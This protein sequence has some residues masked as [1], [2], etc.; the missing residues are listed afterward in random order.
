MPGGLDIS[1]ADS[2]YLNRIRECLPHLPVEAVRANHDGLVNDVL[3][4]NERLVFRFPKN[5]TW[6]RDL[7]ANEI[8]VIQLARNYLDVQIP[9]IEYQAADLMAYRFIGGSALQR[10]DILVLDE[11][12]QDVIAHQLATYLKQLHGIPMD[13]VERHQIAQSDTNRG[14]RVWVRLFDDVQR[15]LFPSMIPHAREWVTNHF[16]PILAD[17]GFMNYEP[18]LINGDTTPYHILFDRQAR[19]VSGVDLLPEKRCGNNESSPVI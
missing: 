15:E 9:Q 10:N 17:E 14:H 18:C 6:A 2:K 3:I 5:E 8:K 4:V 13:E 19:R 7:L 16:A 12:A 11:N 1:A